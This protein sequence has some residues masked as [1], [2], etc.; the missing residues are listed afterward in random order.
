MKSL[1]A[2]TLLS[3]STLVACGRSPSPQPN[4]EA[5]GP[6]PTFTKDVAPIVFKHCA[7]CHRPGQGAPFTLLG[8]DDVRGKAEKIVRATESRRMPPW[9]PDTVE[10]GFAGERRLSSLEI[11]TFKRWVESGAAEGDARDLPARP[12]WPEGWQLGTPDL[13]L[14]PARPYVLQPQTEDVFRNLVLRVPLSSD[15]FVRAVEF[16]PGDAPVHHAVVHLD[17]TAASRRQDGAD[18]RPGF[19]GMGAIGTQEP[20]GHF[21]GWAPGRGPIQSADGM[22]WR[23]HRGTD[24]VLEL[25]LIPGK[26]PVSVSPSVALYFSAG[27]PAAS[28]PLMFKMASKAIDIPAGA[29]DYAITDRYVLPVDAELLSLYPHAHFLGKEMHVAATLPDGTARDLLRIRQWSFHWQQDY[30]Y[31]RPVVLPRGTTI[32]MRFTYDNS[33]G[34]H[35]NPH[36]P[37]QRVT[38]GQRSTDEMGNLLLQLIPHSSADRA[39]LVAD[40]AAREIAMNVAGAELLVRLNPDQPE[41][42]TFLGS[43]YI[44]AGRIADGLPYLERAL[45]LDPASAKAH[46]EMGGALLKQNRLPDALEHFRRAVELSP[47]DDRL[48]YNFGK[49]LAAAGRPADAAAALDRALGIN[50]DLAEAHDELGVLLF[51]GGRLN[52]AIAHFRRA[53]ELAPDFAI[54]HSDLGG[55]LAQAG[56]RD[57]ALAH[58]RRALE[59]DPDNAAAKENLQRLSRRGGKYR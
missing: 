4:R 28:A 36:H 9:L 48:I 10:P 54:A 52:D 55:A 29:R 51:A 59:L 16:R 3:L 7:P 25:H 53:V 35:E 11:D 56:R 19:D 57:E 23:L 41:N 15:R 39:R 8:Y 33:D 38:V 20:D 49:A 42:L 5:P 26:T 14:T 37:P 2:P 34:N 45:K 13:V 32:S 40:A 44:D 46:N 17:R 58:I 12:A 27:A 31:V 21:V 47:R 24:L 30:R 6:V 1:L 43:S 50:P 18:G 22:P